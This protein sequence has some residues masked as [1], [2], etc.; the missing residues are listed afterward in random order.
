MQDFYADKIATLRGREL[1][2]VR[3]F[4][5]ALAVMIAVVTFIPT[6]A[7]VLSF[8][9]Y[10]LSGHNLTVATI[11]TAFQFFNIIRSLLALARLRMSADGLV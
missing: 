1:Q 7:S 9:T 3:K 10:A 5:M 11:F 4:S 2:A 6:L 8:I